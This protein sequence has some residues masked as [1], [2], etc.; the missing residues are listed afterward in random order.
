MAP[1]SDEISPKMPPSCPQDALGRP[2][3]APKT[4]QE[5][6]NN[7]S[8]TPPRRTTTPP[9][10]SQLRPAAPKAAKK[11]SKPRFWHLQTSI[12][13]APDLDFGPSI[14]RFSILQTL[15]CI[16][17]YLLLF[18]LARWRGRSFA[19]RWIVRGI[20]YKGMAEQVAPR[21]LQSTLGPR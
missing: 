8:K 15:S 4:A 13:D 18:V 12:F 5:P 16:L 2:C 21:V 11:T 14:R 9:G 3:L 19:A 10:C 7:G 1:F 20:R 17:S 6:P